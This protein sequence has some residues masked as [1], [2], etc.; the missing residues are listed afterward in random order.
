MEDL[1]L[2][3]AALEAFAEH[4]EANEEAAAASTASIVAHNSNN[5]TLSL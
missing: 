2:D 4:L 3:P 1:N 5:E